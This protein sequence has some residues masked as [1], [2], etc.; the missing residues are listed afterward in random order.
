MNFLLWVSTRRKKKMS[1]PQKPKKVTPFVDY[2]PAELRENKTWEIVYYALDPHTNTLKIKRNRVRPLKSVSERRKLGKRMVLEVNKRLGRGWNPFINEDEFRGYTRFSQVCKIFL[3][4]TEKEVRNNDKRPDTLRSY[5]SFLKNFQFFLSEIGESDMFALKFEH[6][7]LR[8]FIDH[9]YY[10]RE[11]SARTRNNYLHFFNTFSE[12]MI[13]RQYISKNPTLRIEPLPVSRKTRIVIPDEVLKHIFEY[14]KKVSPQ[15][16]IL[17]LMCYY[18]LI[19]RTEM[20]KI[21]VRDI[22]LKNSVIYITSETA[23]NK[24][25]LPV[26][27]PDILLPELANHLKKANNQ[28]FVFGTNFLP[29]PASIHP[30]KIS[31]QWDKL[32]SKLNLPQEYQWY[33][34]KDT[35]ITNLLK[36]GVPLISVRDQARHHSSN[37]TDAYTP[38]EILAANTDIREAKI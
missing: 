32:R 15:Y 34:L 9:I 5:A 6:S 35:G 13:R 30:K 2:I 18:C 11:N 17:C 21:R 25:N 19:R 33:S 4:R 10:D 29:G 36:A 16:H 26:T 22:I 1:T 27:I 7:L 28:D 23:K 12:W 37:Q 3:D 31:D 38:K 20:T 8:D 24:K 14:L